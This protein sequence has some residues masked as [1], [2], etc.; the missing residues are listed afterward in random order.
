MKIAILGFGTIGTGVYEIIST[1]KAKS[2]ADVEVVKVL[3]LPQN[4]DK[5][6]IITDNYDDILQDKSIDCVVE[7]MGGLHPAYEFITAAMKAKKHVVTA[8]KAVV[9]KYMEEFIALALE[10]KVRFLFEASTGGGIP[11]IASLEK[12]KRVDDI[13]ELYGI[14]NGTSNYILDAMTN[15]G[16]DFDEVLKKAQELGYAEADPSADID[17]YDVQNKVVISSAVAYNT[18]INME[19]FPCYSLRTINSIDINYFKKLNRTIKYIGEAVVNHTGYEAYVMPN[20]LANDTVEANVNSNFNI[21]TLYGQ[22]I[23]PLKFYGQGA[24]KLPTAN[25]IVQDILDI[26]SPI[27]S[28]I[29]FSNKLAYQPTQENVY[30]IR[31]TNT[32]DM[33]NIETKEEFE[34]QT[35]YT[36]KPMVASTLVEL[37]KSID[38]SQAFVAKLAAFKG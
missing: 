15:Q 38:D 35:Y 7:T 27:G 6:D 4:K 24:G 33:T 5:L 17:G 34:G 26:Q 21:A 10:N 12:A 16:K 32:V 31:S 9:A 8:N 13:S 28:L 37:V 3:D 18:K 11:W 25:A 20:A 22:S 19:D 30:V 1:Y 36:T 14:F 2:L 23:G 29:D